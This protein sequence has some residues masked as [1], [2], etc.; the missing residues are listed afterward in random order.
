MKEQARRLQLSF[1][2]VSGDDREGGEQSEGEMVDVR[3]D[4]TLH[5]E[6]GAS[7]DDQTSRYTEGPMGRGRLV[8]AERSLGIDG[9]LDD[10]SGENTPR[11][12]R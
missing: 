4:H 10:E 3:L 12:V 1:S 8:D 11:M 7:Q 6:K 9:S 2:T 5:V